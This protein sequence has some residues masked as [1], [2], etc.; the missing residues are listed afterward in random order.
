MAE[1]AV[2]GLGRFGRAVVHNLALE[3]QDVLAIDR[4][5]ARLKLVER[6][7]ESTLCL[8]TTDEAALSSLPLSRMAT[9]VVTIGSR[10]PEASLLTVA[11]LQEIGVPRIVARAFDPRH[12]RLLRELGAHEVLNPEDE[13]AQ[14]LALR[15]ANPGVSDQIRL[16]DARVAEVELPEAF[17]GSTLEELALPAR[18]EVAVLALRRRS[19]TIL[20]PDPTERIESGDRGILVGPAVSL[21]RIAALA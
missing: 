18:Y 17:V 5:A 10:A 16:G 7:A 1:F 13:M 14:R 12:A 21:E 2:I 9:V 20:D 15:L 3:G 11:V 4:D 8:D 19:E 6:E